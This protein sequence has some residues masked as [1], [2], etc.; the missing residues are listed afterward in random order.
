MSKKDIKKQ[1][2]SFEER[3]LSL[4]LRNSKEKNYLL[5]GERQKEK[6]RHT[7]KAHA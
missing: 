5:D 7:K 2:K 4:R 3:L 6:A 1:P